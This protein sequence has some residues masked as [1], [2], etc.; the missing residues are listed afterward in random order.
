MDLK[1][2]SPTE[3]GKELNNNNKDTKDLSDSQTFIDDFEQNLKEVN[4]PEQNELQKILNE[5]YINPLEKIDKP[6][7]CLE[8]V[9][10]NE[11][12]L[13][14][15]LGDFSLIIGKAKS[16][17]TFFITIAIAAAINTTEP[18]LKLFKGTLPDNKK[19][20]LFFDTEQ[21]KYHVYK[22]VQRICKLSGIQSPKNFKAYGLRSLTPKERFEVIEYAIRTTAN[23]GLIVIDGIRDLV[24]DINSPEQATTTATALLN[25]SQ[26]QNIHIVTVLHQNKGDANARG[27]LGTEL[28]NKAQTTISITKDTANKEISIVAP[29]YCRDKDF[30]EFA[31]Q[32]DEN[33]L[34]CLSENWQLNSEKTKKSFSPVD[35]DAAT[36]R[37]IL[38]EIFKKVD[39][40]TYTKL[41]TQLK[42]E[43]ARFKKT[44]GDNKCREFIEYY[45]NESWLK[46][47]GTSGTRNCIY[48]LSIDNDI[49]NF[50]DLDKLC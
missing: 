10:N 40:P 39:K 19:T 22:A 34:P 31:F 6:P 33:G 8:I 50:N 32:I 13:I 47:E 16:R 27:H 17:K 35:I 7:V 15:T 2:K 42:L 49:D 3:Q 28:T 43:L 30:N 14:G 41:Q 4:E 45:L 20:V 21:S 9:Q 25:W 26:T 5:C 18:V 37:N 1:E 23:L 29:E 44:I 12:F 38:R 36:H 48:T 11:S 24:T 46:F